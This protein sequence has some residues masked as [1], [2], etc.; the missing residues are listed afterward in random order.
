LAK[1]IY[2][3]GGGQKKSEHI[4]GGIPFD[5]VIDD[6]EK[7]KLGRYNWPRNSLQGCPK[8]FPR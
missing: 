7:P 4:I 8:V 5:R 2:H 6:Y 3:H 1:S